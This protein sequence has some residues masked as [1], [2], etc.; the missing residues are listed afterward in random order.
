MQS[1]NLASQNWEES[2]NTHHP[3]PRGPYH[4]L[5][6]AHF[7]TPGVLLT[8]TEPCPAAQEELGGLGDGAVV[9]AVV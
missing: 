8:H 2:T 5:L 7:G 3:L 6:V 4:S 1:H 9:G